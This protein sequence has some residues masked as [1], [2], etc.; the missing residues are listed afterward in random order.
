MMHVH[1]EFEVSSFNRSVDRR[2]S[3]L[4][5]EGHVTRATPFLGDILSFVS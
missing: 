4:L 1:T 3:Q 5:K 2:G